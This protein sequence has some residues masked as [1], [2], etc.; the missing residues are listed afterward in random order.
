MLLSNAVQP[1]LAEVYPMPTMCQAWE[2]LW[3]ASVSACLSG[4]MVCGAADVEIGHL[5]PGLVLIKI[6]KK[7]C[8]TSEGEKEGF[9]LFW[10]LNKGLSMS[11][12]KA[13]DLSVCLFSVI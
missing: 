11:V 10:W 2:G 3:E 5:D 13:S 8:E 4:T 7:F 6:L 12:R 1:S 9:T